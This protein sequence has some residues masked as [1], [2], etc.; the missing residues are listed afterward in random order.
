[1]TIARMNRA[2]TLADLQTSKPENVTIVL[3]SGAMDR[4]MAAFI[5]ATGAAFQESY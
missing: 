2:I 1:M 4:A 5:I 3:L